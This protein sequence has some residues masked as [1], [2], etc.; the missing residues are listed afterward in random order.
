MVSAF[1]SHIP[2]AGFSSLINSAHVCATTSIGVFRVAACCEEH[3]ERFQLRDFAASFC[4]KWRILSGGT[5]F[6]RS[7]CIF[8]K[9]MPELGR[10]EHATGVA[11]QRLAFRQNLVFVMAVTLGRVEERHAT[12][13][14]FM[15]K[16]ADASCL[17]KTAGC[18]GGSVPAAESMADTKAASP[19]PMYGTVKGWALLHYLPAWPAF[20]RNS[21]FSAA[22]AF[23]NAGAMQNAACQCRPFQIH[24]D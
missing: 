22:V 12:F 3:A 16:V 15:Y 5:V 4:L 14:G 24:D 21:A 19:R 23:S 20:S 7:T 13:D 11:F 18:G 9:F 6:L 17:V 1:T 8:H 10:N 2:S